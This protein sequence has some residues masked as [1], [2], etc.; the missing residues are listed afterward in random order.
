M[1]EPAVMKSPPKPSRWMFAMITMA[2]L[3]A[4]TAH[5]IYGMQMAKAT[6][7]GWNNLFSQNGHLLSPV[8]PIR[9]RNYTSSWTGDNVASWEHLWITISKFTHVHR[10]CPIGTDIGFA[11]QPTGELFVRWIQLGIFHPFCRVHSSGDHGDGKEPWSFDENV[12]NIVR[13]FIELR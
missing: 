3:A 6:Y 11:E 10:V 8:L 1:N 9:E 12:T 7:K 4:T 2:T 5:N 13:K